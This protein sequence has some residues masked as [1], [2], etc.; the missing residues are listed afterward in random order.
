MTACL[1]SMNNDGWNGAECKPALA[2]G[3]ALGP[4]FGFW[5]GEDKWDGT[6]GTNG[7]DDTGTSCY[8]DCSQCLMNGISWNQ[9]VT[10]T[11]EYE[12]YKG[13]GVTRHHCDMGFTYGTWA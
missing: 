9:A 7:I 3:T 6:D 10:T 13:G 11:C 12:H 8:N 4:S 5:K 1:Q 2:N